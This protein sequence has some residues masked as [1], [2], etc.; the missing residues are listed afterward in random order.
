MSVVLRTDKDVEHSGVEIRSYVEEIEERGDDLPNGLTG[1][2]LVKAP[3]AEQLP[4]AKVLFV[5][6]PTVLA[7]VDLLA[8]GPAAIAVLPLVAQIHFV[9]GEI[10]GSA[11]PDGGR[12]G[13]DDF[14]ENVEM[15]REEYRI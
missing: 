12:W 6:R 15:L 13:N 3:A 7:G 5:R 8:F 14:E 2:R 10:S 9:H 11:G 4:H 1:A